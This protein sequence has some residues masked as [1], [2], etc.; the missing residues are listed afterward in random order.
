MQ[1][2]SQALIDLVL[3]GEVEREVAAGR[4]AEPPRLPD[5]ARAR[6][7]GARRRGARRADAMRASE[8]RP[9]RAAA[10]ATG[11]R[12]RR[13]A[14]VTAVNARGRLV[15]RVGLHPHRD[16]RRAGDPRRRARGADAAVRLRAARTEVDQT[17]RFQAQQEARLALDAL[18]REIHCASAVTSHD[19]HAAG[20]ARPSARSTLG[21]YCP[22]RRRRRPSTSPGARVGQHGATRSGASPALDGGRARA[23]AACRRPTT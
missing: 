16:A 4:G 12:G 2:L 21:S 15:G 20:T 22:T 14:R 8:R 7:E 5:H 11:R 9:G 13:R 18:R 6:R 23:P 17:K 10:P 19:R 1:T 3:A